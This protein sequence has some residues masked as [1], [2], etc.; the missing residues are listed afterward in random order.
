MARVPYLNTEDLAPDQREQFDDDES[1][2]AVDLNTNIDRAVVHAP[3]VLD[4]LSQ[5]LQG[6]YDAV[7]ESRIRELAIL[8][9]ARATE[10][11][12]VW[13]HHVSI[14]RDVGLTEAEIVKIAEGSFEAFTPRE[15]ALLR[16]ATAVAT[17]SVDDDIHAALADRFDH[18]SVIALVFLIT[19]YIQIGYFI[20]VLQVEL[21]EEFVG[22]QLDGLE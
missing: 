21:E 1:P 9:V 10:S 14:A 5:W 3:A 16:Y 7:D 11:R 2:V 6:L 13:Q 15:V 12:Y 8:A 20:D 18:Q 17:D 4:A 19:E 22:W